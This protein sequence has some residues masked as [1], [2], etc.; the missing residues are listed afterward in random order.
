M[1][2]DIAGN[3]QVEFAPRPI[4]MLITLKLYLWAQV[5]D[6]FVKKIKK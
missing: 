3:A 2:R 1:G 5:K 4:G 6:N